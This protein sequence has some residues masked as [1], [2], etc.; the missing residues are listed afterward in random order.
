MLHQ[1]QTYMVYSAL[2]FR[3]MQKKTTS[4]KIFAFTFIIINFFVTLVQKGTDFMIQHLQLYLLLSLW[5]A[6]LPVVKPFS[7]LLLMDDKFFQFLG[8]IVNFQ[9]HLFLR[10]VQFI[11]IILLCKTLNCF[12]GFRCRW[13]LLIWTVL[14]CN[15]V[16]LVAELHLMN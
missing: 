5:P 6:I 11:K 15:C 9:L 4:S 2:F 3:T 14:W 8:L 12:A 7:T 1:F 16:F 10:T 13:L